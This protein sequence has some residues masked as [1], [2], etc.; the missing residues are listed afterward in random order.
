[1]KIDENIRFMH[2]VEDL[3]SNGKLV[4]YVQLANMLS[5]NKASISD[6]KSGRKKISIELLRRMK[7]SYP[8]VNINWIIMGD[9]DM[10][11]SNE[12]QEKQTTQNPTTPTDYLID[13]IKEKDRIIREQAE[14]IGRLKELAKDTISSSHQISSLL[15]TDVGIVH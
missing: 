4:D 9:G 12:I 1:M 8:E 10:Y 5:T 3:K 6:I 7:I 2:L 13:M 11:C 14:E 15:E